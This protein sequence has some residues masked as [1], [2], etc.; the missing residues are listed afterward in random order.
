VAKPSSNIRRITV[1]ASDWSWTAAGLV[2]WLV[3]GCIAGSSPSD[4]AVL[5]HSLQ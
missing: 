5:L 2:A 1:M 3:V 4:Y